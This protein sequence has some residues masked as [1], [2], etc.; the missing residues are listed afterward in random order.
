MR[1]R[2]SRII[3]GIPATGKFSPLQTSS[4]EEHS[5]STDWIKISSKSMVKYP[6]LS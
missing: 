1:S 2:I 6:F 3:E 5:I 4:A